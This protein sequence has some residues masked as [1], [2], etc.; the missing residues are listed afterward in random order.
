MKVI[1]KTGRRK[2]ELGE[3]TGNLEQRRKQFGKDGRAIFRKGKS[4]ICWERL[5]NLREA[6][7]MEQGLFQ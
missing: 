5:D 7:E 6:T 1:V 2:G 3:I 4:V